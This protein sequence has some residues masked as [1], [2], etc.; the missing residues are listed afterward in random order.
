MG[1]INDT[2]IYNK[3][4]MGIYSASTTVSAAS[5]MFCSFYFY[6][7]PAK[8]GGRWTVYGKEFNEKW[9]NFRKFLKDN[10]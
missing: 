5:F 4:L 7:A 6:V 9:K 1:F 8:I 2:W 10:I 3:S